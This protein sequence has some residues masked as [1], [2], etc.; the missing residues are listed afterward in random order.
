MKVIRVRR[1]FECPY[2]EYRATS[3][4][5]RFPVCFFGSR[6]RGLIVGDGIPEFCLLEDEEGSL[7]EVYGT[8]SVV[9]GEER[10]L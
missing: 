3:D 7:V 8:A 5:G 10:G 2:L 4:G 9:F 6:F 1:C